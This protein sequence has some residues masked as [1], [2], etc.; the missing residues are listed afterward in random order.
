MLGAIF[1]G[2]LVTA[3]LDTIGIL[4][5]LTKGVNDLF[6]VEFTKA[7]LYVIIIAIISIEKLLGNKKSVT[8][9]N[10]NDGVNHTKHDKIEIDVD[11][12]DY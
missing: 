4:E 3:F 7:G 2:T 1:W 11:Y 8:T 10:V 9:I 6:G 12:E 5:A